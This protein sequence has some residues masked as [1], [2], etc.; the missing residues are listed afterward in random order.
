VNI[1]TGTFAAIVDERDQLRSELPLL[2]GQVAR[3][4]DAMLRV[5]DYPAVPAVVSRRG[6]GRHTRPGERHL[7]LVEGGQR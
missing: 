7:R 6:Q 3:L 2:R 5:A 4:A 1:D